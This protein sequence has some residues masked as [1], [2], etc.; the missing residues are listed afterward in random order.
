MSLNE[1]RVFS[2]YAIICV[3]C[4]PIAGFNFYCF[5]YYLIGAN[6][7]ISVLLGIGWTAWIFHLDRTLFHETLK[8][9]RGRVYFIVLSTLVFSFGTSLWFGKEQIDKLIIDENS[10]KNRGLEASYREQL[11]PYRNRYF[12]AIRE[13]NELA[14]NIS[15]TDKNKELVSLLE[16]NTQTYNQILNDTN[17][18]NTQKNKVQAN[19]TKISNNIET[20]VKTNVAMMESASKRIDVAKQEFDK[21]DATL[22]ERFESQKTPPDFSRGKKLS[23]LWDNYF[24]IGASHIV[25]LLFI[26]LIEYA[27]L[28]FRGKYNDY[29][30]IKKMNFYLSLPTD[31]IHRF[32]ELYEEHLQ[33]EQAEKQAK[34]QQQQNNEAGEADIFSEIS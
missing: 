31:T 6:F 1:L 15:K 34:E 14:Q 28:F 27:P 29:T 20:N 3:I 4:A 12:D 30:I 26:L 19:V 10:E 2:F 13:N 25:A 7:W 33:K 11:D 18:T 23:A 21:Q 5:L 24:T 17:Y 8:K 9:A 32:D 22:K 16:K